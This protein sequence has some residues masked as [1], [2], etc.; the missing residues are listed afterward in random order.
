MGGG[1]S[2]EIKETEYEKA[3][4]DVAM[5][6]LDQFQAQII[7]FRN[8]WIDDV[9]RDTSSV[10]NM[11]AGQV[12]ADVA[13][14]RPA[15]LPLNVDP[16][17]GAGMSMSPSLAAG[18]IAAKATVSGTQT[19]RDQKA[20]GLQAALHVMRGES[21]DAQA[22][23]QGLARDS[24]SKA[25]GDAQRKEETSQTMGS[26]ISSALGGGAALY[27]NSKYDNKGSDREKE[28]GQ[29]GSGF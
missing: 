1:G 20:A 19:I 22:G 21:T 14:Y 29:S 26:S 17:S 5:E 23:M 11:V 15:A 16:S 25:I 9:T 24:V 10:E 7:P 3:L 4:A 12:N 18:N 6:E 13:Q 28:N 8:S 27:L 2:N